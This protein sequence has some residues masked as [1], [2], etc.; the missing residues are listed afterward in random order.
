MYDKA[1]ELNPKDSDVYKNKLVALLKLLRYKESVLYE[2]VTNYISGED[3]LFDI[4]YRK[5]KNIIREYIKNK[6]FE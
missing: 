4:F 3:T 1:I 5:E 2:F 6:N